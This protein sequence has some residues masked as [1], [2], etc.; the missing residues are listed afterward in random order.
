LTISRDDPVGCRLQT[1]KGLKPVKEPDTKQDMLGLISSEWDALQAV[2][3][4]MNPEKMIQPGVVG[5]WSVKDILA[6]ITTWEGL[7]IQ[8]LEESLR[9]ETPNRP[10]PGSTWDGLD[11]L[12]EQIYRENR[13]KTLAEVRKAFS[14]THQQ[15]VRTVES[16]EEKDLFD[17]VR[18]TW[19]EGDPMW[20]LVA[21]NTWWHYKEHRKSIADWMASS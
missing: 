10:A 16:M 8:W 19:R 2:L 18:F 13:D 3:Q 14:D 6:H 21:G 12:N 17:P 4:E 11:N 15:V 20:H 7:M 5:V 1:G 9:G